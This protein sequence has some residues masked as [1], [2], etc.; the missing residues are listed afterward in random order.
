MSAPLRILKETRPQ[1]TAIVLMNNPT[2]AAYR[3]Y[4][5]LVDIKRFPPAIVHHL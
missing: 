3:E 5:S 2:L 4:Q 1:K